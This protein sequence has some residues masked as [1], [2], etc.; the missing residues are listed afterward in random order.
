VLSEAAARTHGRGRLVNRGG[1][2]GC[3]R[4]GASVTN[5]RDRGEAGPGGQRSGCE[6]E[7]ERE[8]GRVVVGHRH[9]GPGGAVQS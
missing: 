9:A 7:R 8:R 5:R 6:R 1:R 4:R 2:A 3:G